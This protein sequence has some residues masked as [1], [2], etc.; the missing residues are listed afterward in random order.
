MGVPS[1]WRM[2]RISNQKEHC[3]FSPF[4]NKTYIFF[5]RTAGLE[6]R[7]CIGEAAH[8]HTKLRAVFF[9]KCC[10]EVAPQQQ[11]NMTHPFH[12]NNSAVPEPTNL[13]NN[14][15]LDTGYMIKQCINQSAGSKGIT[16]NQWKQTNVVCRPEQTFAYLG[17][18]WLAP[19]LKKAGVT[20]HVLIAHCEQFNDFERGSWR[21][22]PV[23]FPVGFFQGLLCLYQYNSYIPFWIS[24]VGQCVL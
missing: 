24:M 13:W 22:M 9:W 8:T 11:N 23:I 1:Y 2:H 18:D 19:P 21:R 10:G 16:M 6:F 12:P 15:N 20:N 5:K 7:E 4:N 3:R 14:S 17:C